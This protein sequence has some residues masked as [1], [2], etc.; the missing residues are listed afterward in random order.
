MQASGFR[1]QDAGCRV[2]SR[3]KYS[4]S[5]EVLKG[6]VCTHAVLL[7]HQVGRF[8]CSLGAGLV[9]GVAASA[10]T[11][12][13]DGRAQELQGA[14]FRDCHIYFAIFTMPLWHI[15]YAVTNS[16][17]STEQTA[18]DLAGSC[19][20]WARGLW[21]EWPRPRPQHPWTL[22]RLACRFFSFC[23]C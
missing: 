9:A 14:G 21:L 8:L 12:P 1:V 20:H 11:T 22:S 15:Y 7:T 5:S 19:A 18:S 6:N 4:H 2:Q 3:I 17:Y 23:F 13:M 16:W 10:P